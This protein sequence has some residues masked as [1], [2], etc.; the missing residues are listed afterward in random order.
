M[1]KI[2]RSQQSVSHCI[3]PLS[4]PDNGLNTRT[5]GFD[6][7]I[8]VPRF[9]THGSERF[10]RVA[11]VQRLCRECGV[12]RKTVPEGVAFPVRIFFLYLFLLSV[13]R[14]NKQGLFIRRIERVSR[15][16]SAPSRVESSRVESN[17]VERT[18]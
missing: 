7:C 3:N 6:V 12:T 8:F 2:A 16:D 10:S 5:L 1:R 18:L 13:R 9:Q 4:H 14:A 15:S 17:R 11:E